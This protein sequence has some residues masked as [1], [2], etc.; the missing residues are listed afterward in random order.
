VRTLPST[1]VG[2]PT[3]SLGALA[4]TERVSNSL[5]GLTLGGIWTAPVVTAPGPLTI[6]VHQAGGG[7]DFTNAVERWSSASLAASPA[8][9]TETGINTVPNGCTITTA[10]AGSVVSW[11]LSNGDAARVYLV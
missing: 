5:P 8:T 11:L 4:F 9:D 1:S 10:R 3:D 2:P 7:F 6:S